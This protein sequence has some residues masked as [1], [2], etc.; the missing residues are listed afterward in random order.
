M[1]IALIEIVYNE[2]TCKIIH[3]HY[4]KKNQESID[5]LNMLALSFR[6]WGNVKNSS[7]EE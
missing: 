5:V 7:E 2:H 4:E 1:C 3:G 6:G